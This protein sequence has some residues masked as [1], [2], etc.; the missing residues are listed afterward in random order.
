MDLI[1][2]GRCALDLYCD[3]LGAPLSEG[4]SLS[5]YLGGCP[6]NVAVGASRLGLKVAML[7][8][9]GTEETGDFA[10]RFLSDNGI[11]TSH[12]GRD[13]AARTPLVLAGVQPPDRFQVTYYSERAAYFNLDSSDWTP[14]WLATARAVL[15]SGN[16]LVVPRAAAE[17]VRIASTARAV[18]VKVI[19]D[20]DYRPVL[21]CEPARPVLESLLPWVDLLVGTAE[22]Y[23]AVG[24]FEAA[25]R[26]VPGICLRKL[27]P[28][29]AELS[30]RGA[31]PLQVPGFSVPVLNTLGAGDAFLAGFLA[32]WLGDRPLAECLRRGNASGA[33]VVSRHGCAPA[34]PCAAEI[35]HFLQH[36]DARAP[37]LAA[38]HRLGRQRPLPPV[39]LDLSSLGSD[40]AAR[41]RVLEAW[42][43]AGVMDDDAVFLAQV[44]H[45]WQA[46][47]TLEDPALAL[48]WWPQARSLL[49]GPEPWPAVLVAEAACRAWDRDL[50]VHV[51]D[52]AAMKEGQ[53]AGLQPLAW[54]LPVADGEVLLSPHGMSR[55]LGQ[56]ISPHDRRSVSGGRVGRPP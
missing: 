3:Q 39:V 48:R 41:N 32:A 50:I 25:Q 22:E 28:A 21:W 42:P 18:G 45:R 31:P 14:D 9:V 17:I 29:G 55:V 40:R 43:E 27:G 26:M 51:T 13:P 19:F 1:C 2:V 38:L 44:P 46:C 49:V 20:I 8:R 6:T 35:E 30:D 15:V 11:D 56:G 36:P 10:V 37:R 4:Q 33:I 54:R 47:R 52:E 23:Q 12:V 7:T 5:M 53:E 34:M 16:S 24:G